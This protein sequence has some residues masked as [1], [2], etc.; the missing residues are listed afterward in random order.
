MFE[1]ISNLFVSQKQNKFLTI[2]FKSLGLGKINKIL[3]W[4]YVVYILL[5][6]ILLFII[7]SSSKDLEGELYSYNPDTQKAELVDKKDEPH[8]YPEQLKRTLQKFV[9][10]I[11]SQDFISID[12]KY[13]TLEKYFTPSAWEQWKTFAGGPFYNDIKENKLISRA[14]IISPPLYHGY[15]Y[16]FDDLSWE[17][18]ADL[19]IEYSGSM[20]NK[21]KTIQQIVVTLKQVN[22]KKNPLGVQIDSFYV[23]GGSK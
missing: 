14:E 16:I 11:Y 8:L 15:R 17:F 9:V 12:K 22:P 1:K 10:D 2:Y 20:K 13:P 5:F 3:G 4:V 21:N 19:L 23:M 6:F 18:S 7:H